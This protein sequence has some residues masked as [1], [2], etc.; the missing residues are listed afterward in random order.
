MNFSKI[1][2]FLFQNSKVIDN[3]FIKRHLPKSQSFW[4]EHLLN[5]KYSVDRWS[6]CSHK[7]VFAGSCIIVGI[8]QDRWTKKCFSA[9]EIDAG[10]VDSALVKCGAAR[11]PYFVGVV[12]LLKV[13]LSRKCIM[14]VMAL[15]FAYYHKIGL[16][17]ITFLGS[18]SLRA[19]IMP[20]PRNRN[21]AMIQVHGRNSLFTTHKSTHAQNED[22]R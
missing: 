8:R 6:Y 5:W 16:D 3:N 11:G 19:S 14:G 1:R 13:K 9:D 21:S 18:L 22:M 17:L 10:W 2:S 15:F 4:T 12:G 20:R 7:W